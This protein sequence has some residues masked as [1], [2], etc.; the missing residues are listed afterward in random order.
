M[1]DGIVF[2]DFGRGR[3]ALRRTQESTA[4]HVCDVGAVGAVDDFSF[5]SGIRAL[6]AALLVEARAG[7]L[8]YDRTSRHVAR[9]GMDHY[10]VTLCLEGH[11]SY[12][13]GRRSVEMRP[14]DLC[15]LDMAQPSRTSVSADRASKSSRALSLLLP[16][17]AL[18]PLLAA[19]D[20][21]D[22][23]LI[24]GRSP[25]AQ[26]LAAH[27]I[28]AYAGEGGT[29]SSALA[30][31]IADAVGS[32]RHAAEA[33][34]Q[35]NRTLLLAAIKRHIE[36]NLHTDAVSVAQLC[37]DFGMSRATLY[38]LFEPE[39]GLS[40]YIS[41]RRLDLA[42]ARLA[43][44]TGASP[45][46]LDLALDLHFSTDSTFV[47]AFR[48]RFGLTPGEVKRLAA[49]RQQGEPGSGVLDSLLRL[50]TGVRDRY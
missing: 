21:S 31:G 17:S 6:D 33:V 49:A 25:H 18:A 13:A 22:A 45:R 15:L 38:R 5:R 50:R 10:Q 40:R 36:A 30:A 28:A 41:D 4:D 35:G 39:G 44:S 24:A 7:A 26:R 23:S 20:G 37:R 34:D 1:S 29:T 9:D 47:R 48:R 46:L 12:A 42:F 11:V 19:P 32:A 2:T 43:S 14:G 8:H 16:R 3:E 27:F